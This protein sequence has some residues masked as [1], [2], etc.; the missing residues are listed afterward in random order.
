MPT[1]LLLP[2]Q[3]WTP[4][5]A[6]PKR[7]LAVLIMG[8]HIK[9]LAPTAKFAERT[10]ATRIELPGCTLLPGLIDAHSHLFLH[11]YN[12]TSWDDQVLKEAEAY[13]TLRAAK[14]AQATLQAGFTSLRDLGTEGA[15]YADVA[16]KRAIDEG[17][18]SGPRLAVATRAIVAAGSYGPPARHYR[19]DCCLP[20]G[21]EEASGIEE[22]VLAVRRQISH[23]A[24]WVKLY[25]DYRTGP[26]GEVCPTFSEDELRAAVDRAHD[27]DRPVAAHAMVDEAMRRAV[28]AGVD[29]I[30]HGYGGTEST[31]ALMAQKNVSFLPTLTAPEAIGEYFH[32]HEHDDPPTESMALAAEGFRLARRCGVTIG[33]GS[34]VG[35]FAHG[36]NQRELAWMVKLGMSPLGALTAATAVNAQILGWAKEL[37]EVRAGLLADLIAV[38]GDP[39]HDIAAVRDVRFVMKGGEI[40]RATID[41]QH[42]G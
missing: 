40:V 37:G 1:I 4:G 16:L 7:S 38:K 26:N 20:Q 9:D 21:A 14:H 31:F 41:S 36:T 24:D 6:I 18:V 15:G 25:A 39:T 5:D 29:T 22:I 32:S 33:C 3:V 23:G 2:E 27:S 34:D 12:E 17:I 19:P 30:E 28:L 13:R 11:P 8:S 10:D 35:V 42:A